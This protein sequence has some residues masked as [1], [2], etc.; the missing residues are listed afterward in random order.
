MT[1]FAKQEKSMGERHTKTESV[2]CL[3]CGS[4][5]VFNPEAQKLKCPHCGAEKELEF[6][7]L[8]SELNIANGFSVERLWKESEAVVFFCDNC[9]AK[10][11]L[12]ANETAK[13]CP[14]CGTAHVQKVD[15]LAGLKPNA[16]IP[17]AFDKM[18]AVNY[19]KAWAK[20]RFYA[21]RSFKKNISVD[22]V[23]GVYT[24][25]F[26][27]DSKTV[28]SYYGRLGITKT[29]TVGS[30]KNRRTQTYTVWFDINGTFNSSFDDVLIT[31]GSKFD[32]KSLDDISPYGTNDSKSYDEEY[33]LGYMS[34]HYDSELTDC[35]QQAKNRIDSSIRRSILGQYNYD[36][37]GYL[38]VSTTH[39]D[40]TYKY[41]ML[42]VYVGN[43]KFKQKYFNFYVNGSTGRVAGKTPKSVF[44]ILATVFLGMLVV[45]G[46]FLLVHFLG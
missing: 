26:T 24:P 6:Q 4:N 34:Y 42:P 29:R 44:K 35:W 19:S 22:N 28:S 27:F 3:G 25:C 13:S 31:A 39:L 10:V 5:M 15:E 30:G 32:Q 8:A 46:V 12:T 1:D 41:V 18:Q 11:V 9:G 2:K 40:V 7:T 20:R 37:V 17:F 16:V 33:F 36:K 38:N 21:P 23:Q 14:F 45:A 43:Y